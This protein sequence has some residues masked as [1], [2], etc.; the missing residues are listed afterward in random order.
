VLTNGPRIPGIPARDDDDR[1]ARSWFA[2]FRHPVAVPEVLRVMHWG[3]VPV[4]GFDPAVVGLPAEVCL[5]Y[6]P[7]VAAEQVIDAVLADPNAV[8]KLADRVRR[9]AATVHAPDRWAERLLAV[10]TANPVR[11]AAARPGLPM[12]SSAVDPGDVV[13]Q[14]DNCPTPPVEAAAHRAVLHAENEELAEEL[15]LTRA[16]L[17]E[18]RDRLA[19]V[20]PLRRHVLATAAARAFR[21]D[22]AIQDRLG[23]APIRPAVVRTAAGTPADLLTRAAAADAETATRF[24]APST[25]ATALQGYRRWSRLLSGRFLATARAVKRRLRRP[26][27]H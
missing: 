13:S 24:L 14:L 11:M 16:D 12:Q 3:V 15:T 18:L 20:T 8:D 10:L 6:G 4:L 22:S 5:R 19:K 25:H 2:V 27:D 21:A 1:L 7:P 9:H 23:T 17:T 26:N